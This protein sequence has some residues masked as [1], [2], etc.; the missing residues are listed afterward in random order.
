MLLGRQIAAAAA[1]ATVA[2]FCFIFWS[3]FQR[4]NANATNL[5]VIPTLSG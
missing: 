2:I 5:K 3:R 4:L 1:A